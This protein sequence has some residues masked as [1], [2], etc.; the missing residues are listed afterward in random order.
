VPAIT[1]ILAVG[2]MQGNEAVWRTFVN[3]V[4]LDVYKIDGA[5]VIGELG[6]G[7]EEAVAPR[8]GAGD[9]RRGAGRRAA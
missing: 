6:G 3:V 1:R 5:V 8:A 7:D 4:A 2:A 9:L